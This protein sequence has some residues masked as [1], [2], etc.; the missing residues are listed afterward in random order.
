MLFLST[1]NVELSYAPAVPLHRPQKI[2][3]R[4]S[5][6]YLS[7]RVH[8]SIIHKSQRWKEPECPSEDEWVNKKWSGQTMEYYSAM[9]RKEALTQTT[10]V[11]NL[12]NIMTNETSRTQQVTVYGSIY[13]KRNGFKS[14]LCH[15]LALC[16]WAN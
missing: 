6:R 12:E 15:S 3:S 16:P 13:M 5:N 1:F 10:T 14:Q 4:G 9:K 2:E 11:I 8:S 7:T